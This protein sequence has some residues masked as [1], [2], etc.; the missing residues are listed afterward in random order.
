MRSVGKKIKR[1]KYVLVEEVITK[2]KITAI[3]IRPE[4]KIMEVTIASLNGSDEVVSETVLVIDS[5]QY[6]L[7]YSSDDL[8]DEGKQEGSFREDDLWKIIDKAS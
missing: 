2:E 5:E 3:L 7:L 4:T 6:E 8:F 1:N